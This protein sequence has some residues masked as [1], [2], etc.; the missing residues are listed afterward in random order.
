MPT[1]DTDHAILLQDRCQR[2]DNEFLPFTNRAIYLKITKNALDRV[3]R[4]KP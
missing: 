3:R 2:Y 4:N 1:V